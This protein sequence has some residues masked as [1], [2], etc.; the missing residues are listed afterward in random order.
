M[1]ASTK[2]SLPVPLEDTFRIS[3]RKSRSSPNPRCLSDLPEPGTLASLQ[4]PLFNDDKYLFTASVRLLETISGRTVSIGRKWRIVFDMPAWRRAAAKGE[5]LFVGGAGPAGLKVEDKV[6]I[7][8]KD[9]PSMIFAFS[10][11]EGKEQS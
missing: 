5:D 7:R 11:F 6:I 8:S 1:P 9:L 4:V 2:P 3:A 10:K